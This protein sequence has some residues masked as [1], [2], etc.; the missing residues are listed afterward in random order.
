MSLTR[1]IGISC[2]KYQKRRAIQ[3][4]DIDHRQ[5]EDRYAQ[6][7]TETTS[8]R[9]LTISSTPLLSVSKELI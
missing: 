6:T 7:G 5:H 2:L 4:T 3:I 9:E 1:A 8:W